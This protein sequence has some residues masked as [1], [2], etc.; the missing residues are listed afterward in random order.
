MSRIPK[1]LSPGEEQFALD[2]QREHLAPERE[3]VFSKRKFRF[4]FAFLAQKIAVE[5]EGGIWSKG[6]HNRGK[7]FEQDAF[8]YN[9][10]TKMGWRVLRYSTDMV[11]QG[12]AINDVLEMLR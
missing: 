11:M 3:W 6:A 9:L 7:H 12:Q 10:A 4:D 8:K 1:A 5:V 2:C